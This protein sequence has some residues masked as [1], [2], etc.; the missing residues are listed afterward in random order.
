MTGFQA[1]TQYKDNVGTVS[2]TWHSNHK[3]HAFAESIGVPTEEDFPIGMRISRAFGI[4]RMHPTEDTRI[5]ASTRVCVFTVP[6]RE[7]KDRNVVQ[8]FE[9]TP[10]DKAQVKC[11]TKSIKDIEKEVLDWFK[12]L[13]VVLLT[14]TLKQEIMDEIDLGDESISL[15]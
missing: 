9:S 5:A 14:P 10:A 7:I 15:D 3:L 2:V 13:D 11:Y 8:Y 12:E 6:R 4:N 1:S